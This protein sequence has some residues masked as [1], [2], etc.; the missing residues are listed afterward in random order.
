MHTNLN[1]GACVHLSVPFG[2]SHF[3]AELA[4]DV[5]HACT[6]CLTYYI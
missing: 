6:E 3:I 1:I 2:F 5:A 4:T